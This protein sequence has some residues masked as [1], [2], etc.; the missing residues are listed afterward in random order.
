MLNQTIRHQHRFPEVCLFSGCPASA[1]KEKPVLHLAAFCQ[2]QLFAGQ[3]GR[4]KGNSKC[5]LLTLF[6]LVS[7][8]ISRSGVL[9]ISWRKS[10]ALPILELTARPSER[11]V[12]S[13]KRHELSGGGSQAEWAVAFQMR[14]SPLG[15]FCGTSLSLHSPVEEDVK[16]AGRITQEDQ[17]V[18]GWRHT[19]WASSKIVSGR[20]DARFER[21][22]LH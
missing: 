10:I 21:Q 3:H 11:L 16:D 9:S 5:P 18:G 20:A 17:A 1:M 15:R 2:S 6:F 14:S 4:M 12:L 8:R 7:R 22:W 13:Q 19:R